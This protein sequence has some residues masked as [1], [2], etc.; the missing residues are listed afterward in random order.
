MNEWGHITYL[1]LPDVIKN[2]NRKAIFENFCL[3][4]LLFLLQR[5][6]GPQRTED[7]R[8]RR[9]DWSGLRCS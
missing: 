1:D 4:P 3:N 6:L 5:L 9:G 8:N 7:P 2:T